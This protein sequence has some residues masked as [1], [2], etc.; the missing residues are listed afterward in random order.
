MKKTERCGGNLQ[1]SSNR[2]LS[3]DR[4]DEKSQERS[5]VLKVLQMCHLLFIMMLKEENEKHT[6]GCS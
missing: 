4:F 5:S 6:A 2:I 3:L 1:T